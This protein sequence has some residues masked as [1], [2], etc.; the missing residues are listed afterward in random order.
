MHMIYL[1]NNSTTATAHE[2]RD[3]MLP[4]FCEL[5]GNPS[6]THRFGQESRQAIES[7]RYQVAELIGCDARDLIFTSGGTEADNSAIVGLLAGRP[8]KKTIISTPVEH[9]AVREP[10]KMLSKQGYHII[11]LSVDHAGMLNMQQLAEVV[12][13]PDVAL[14]TTMW[15]NNE[16]GVVWDV[17][18][19]GAL[20]RNAGVPYHVDGVQAAGKLPINLRQL[21]IDSLA[22]SSHKIHGPKGVGALFV[23][24]GVRWQSWVKGGPQERERRGGTEN[25]PG[26]VGFGKAAELAR[27]HMN[28]WPK[29]AALRDHLEQ[30]IMREI[31]DTHVNGEGSPRVPNTTNISFAGVEAEAIL[32]LLSERGIC[33]SAGAA[34]ASGSLEPSHVLQAM[35][36]EE[37]IAHGAIRFSLSRM[38]TH[39]DIEQTL[40]ILPPVIAQLRAVMPVA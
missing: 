2:V 27:Q 24:R 23:R 33:A 14:V 11:E 9:S 39:A 34:C 13:G 31:A 18:A 7:A 5:Y 22:I 28:E 29:I 21:P 20:C 16:T 25:L 3:A 12:A 35:K 36:I 17:A 10:L 40:K 15:A 1:D 37:R 30:S 32:I 6:S 8:G 38:T 19:I 4:Y 26:I